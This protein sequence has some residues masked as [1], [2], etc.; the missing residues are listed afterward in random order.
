MA[1][2]CEEEGRIR[3]AQGDRTKTLMDPSIL[4]LPVLMLGYASGCVTG[5]VFVGG[6]LLPRDD[7]A[8]EALMIRHL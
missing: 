6:C 1:F 7:V 5:R 2:A 4:S 3:I 8:G